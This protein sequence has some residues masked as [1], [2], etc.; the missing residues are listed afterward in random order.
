M[1]LSL[2]F[3]RTSSW[4]LGERGRGRKGKGREG[5]EGDREGKRLGF[6]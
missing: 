5:R 6:L 3:I 1:K 2:S 4:G